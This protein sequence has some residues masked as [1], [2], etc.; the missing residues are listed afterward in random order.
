[1]VI[2]PLPKINKVLSIVLQEER[3]QNYGASRRGVVKENETEVLENLIKSNAINHNF[4]RG[5]GYNGHQG[6][7]GRGGSFKEKVSMHCGKN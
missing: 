7:R 1:M 4:G 2:E 5:R 6:G 3:H